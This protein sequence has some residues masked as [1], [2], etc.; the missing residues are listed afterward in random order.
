MVACI[1]LVILGVYIQNSIGTPTSDPD[2]I[3][4]QLVI[5]RR[6]FEHLNQDLIQVKLK[7]DS[8]TEQNIKLVEKMNALEKDD[9]NLRLVVHSTSKTNAALLDRVNALEEESHVIKQ[10]I[11]NF[12]HSDWN[13]DTLTGKAKASTKENI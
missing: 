9:T 1:T 2:D 6:Q 12:K 4:Q 5:L 10:T 8:T 11:H 7:L 3:T 13:F